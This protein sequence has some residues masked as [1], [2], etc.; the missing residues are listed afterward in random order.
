MKGQ[1]VFKFHTSGSTGNPKK[2]LL[3]REQ[4]AYSAQSTLDFLFG[5]EKPERLLLCIDPTRI[6]GAQ[7][8]TRSLLADAELI[9]QAPSGNPLKSLD[10]S[11][12]LVSLVPF[13]VKKILQQSPE[14]FDLIKKVLIGGADLPGELVEELKRFSTEFYQTFGMT[15]TASHIGIKSI[16]EPFFQ[17]IGDVQLDADSESRLS[18]KGSVTGHKW[19]KTNDLVE[20]KS[21]G[22]VWLGRADLTINTGGIKV[23]PEDIE[24][25][26]REHFPH[27]EFA[28]TSLP[29]PLLGEKV[30]LVARGP[31]LDHMGSLEV[32]SK[33]EMPKMEVLVDKLPRTSNGKLDR[34]AIKSV[35]KDAG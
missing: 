14:K 2:I 19:L 3:K 31:L 13:Q 18:I 30:V 24:G 1:E 8:I 5:T 28:V 16:G 9:L 25:R 22:F 4:L 7:I 15:E 26:I 27:E 6:G 11:V 29:D 21:F 20:I 17:P 32:L 23:Q 33:Y 10:R 35:A 12:D 34:Q